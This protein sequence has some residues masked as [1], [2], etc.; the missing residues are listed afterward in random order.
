MMIIINKILINKKLNRF[1]CQLT[2]LCVLEPFILSRELKKRACFF[3]LSLSLPP[4]DQY[5]R[6]MDEASSR[7]LSAPLPPRLER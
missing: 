4:P 1:D 3:P 5:C 2:L 7:C 6:G